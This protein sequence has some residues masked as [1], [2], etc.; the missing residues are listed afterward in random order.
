MRETVQRYALQ[1]NDQQSTD[2]K[3]EKAVKRRTPSTRVQEKYSTEDMSNVS[4]DVL[5]SGKR[6]LAKKKVNK[7]QWWKGIGEGEQLTA[8]FSFTE[9]SS[10]RIVN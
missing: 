8:R 7:N 4:V 9:S 1:E 2:D 10:T 6:V 5:V 3:R